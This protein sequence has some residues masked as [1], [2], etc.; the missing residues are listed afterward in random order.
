MNTVLSQLPTNTAIVGTVWATA[1]LVSALSLGIAWLRPSYPGWRGWAVGHSALVLGLL[2]GTLRTPETL[3]ASILVGNG[4]V[5]IG[6]GLFV[7]AFQRFSG[8]VLRRRALLLH[9]GVVLSLLLALFVLTVPFDDLTA[10][11][12]LATGYLGVMALTLLQLVV[13]QARVQPALKGA[14]RLN[15]GILI[16]V[17]ALGLPRLLMLA[18]GTHP[19]TAYALNVPNVLMYLSVLLLSVGGT[20]AFWVLHADRR[21]EEVQTLQGELETLVYFDPLTSVLNRRGLWRAH[22]VWARQEGK[23][24]ATLLVFDIDHFKSINDQKGHAVGDEYLKGLS[25]VLREVATR[26]D[27]VSRTGGDEFV[28]LLTGHEAQVERQLNVLTSRL[29]A[30]WG[31]TLGFT[32]S[33]GGTQVEQAEPLDVAMNRADDMMYA[34]KAAGKALRLAATGEQRPEGTHETRTRR[35]AARSAPR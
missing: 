25:A 16:V 35:P 19:E 27:L 29:Y 4:L 3:L 15:L 5:M 8:Q 28:L 7:N 1:T 24:E 33:F 13:H 10:R 34:K 30:G 32:V 17:H 21:R 22:S 23:A 26:E 11:F 31:E 12:L 6:T 9:V 2:V 20:F 18:P 14:Y